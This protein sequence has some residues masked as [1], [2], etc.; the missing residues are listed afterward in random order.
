MDFN[1]VNSPV[2]DVDSK[3]QRKTHES[4]PSDFDQ[5]NIKRE[6]TSVPSTQIAPGIH[7]AKQEEV[8][9][10][11]FSKPTSISGQG[12]SSGPRSQSQ[13]DS[14]TASHNLDSR[15]GRFGEVRVSQGEFE[16]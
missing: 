7:V 1:F 6:D 16:K 2:H 8:Y 4:Y 13:N 9:E 5:M 3:H 12:H 14:K 11:Y 15:Q 10:K